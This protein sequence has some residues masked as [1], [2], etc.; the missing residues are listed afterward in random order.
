MLFFQWLV[1]PVTAMKTPA[2]RTPYTQFG[3]DFL[4]SG[5]RS[6]RVCLTGQTSTQLVHSSLHTLFNLWTRMLEGHTFVHSSQLMQDE[7]SRVILNGL[8]QLKTPSSA[9]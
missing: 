7:A 1:S 3:M 5:V 2:T 9:P 6:K 4:D 8:S